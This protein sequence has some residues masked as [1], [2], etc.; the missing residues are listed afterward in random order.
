MAAFHRGTAAATAER[1]REINT[2]RARERK[3]RKRDRIRKAKEK[4]A[5]SKVANW[6]GGSAAAEEPDW[7]ENDIREFFDQIDADKSGT[8]DRA[9]C[10]TLPFFDLATAF[11]LPVLEFSLPIHCLS[12]IS[13]RLSTAFP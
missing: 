6:K 13:R 4:G 10:A 8:L 2:E 7:D 3:I 5:S 12:L 1:K 9:E 11:P